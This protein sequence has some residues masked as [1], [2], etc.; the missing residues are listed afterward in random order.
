MDPI[1]K[2]DYFFC[3]TV[4]GVSILVQMRTSLSEPCMVLFELS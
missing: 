1:T 3:D 2:M 4:V